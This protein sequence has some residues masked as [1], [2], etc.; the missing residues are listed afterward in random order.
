MNFLILLWWPLDLELTPCHCSMTTLVP[1]ET[2]FGACQLEIRWLKV[3]WKSIRMNKTVFQKFEKVESWTLLKNS[4]FSRNRNDIIVHSKPVQK[5]QN[6][7]AKR[8][9]LNWNLKSFTGRESSGKSWNEPIFF[10][11]WPND[12]WSLASKIRI[13]LKPLDYRFVKPP[14]YGSCTV[15]VKLSRAFET[16]SRLAPVLVLSGWPKIWLESDLAKVYFNKL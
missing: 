7:Q 16:K 8:W 3:I 10:R 1:M 15:S 12:N 5:R 11:A 4:H 2:L 14:A 9:P 6:L 13:L